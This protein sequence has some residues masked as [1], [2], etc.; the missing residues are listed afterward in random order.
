MMALLEQKGGRWL[1]GGATE[2]ECKES[3]DDKPDVSAGSI[4]L[5]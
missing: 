5:Q 2:L 1:V 4:Y 3:Y